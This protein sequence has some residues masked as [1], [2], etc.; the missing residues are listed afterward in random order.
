MLHRIDT[1][2]IGIHAIALTVVPRVDWTASLYV[3]LSPRGQ[4]N[5]RCSTLRFPLL[6]WLLAPAE[7][8]ALESYTYHGERCRR[9]SAN[10]RSYQEAIRLY[11]T[12]EAYKELP[13]TDDVLATLNYHTSVRVGPSLFSHSVVVVFCSTH[14]ELLACSRFIA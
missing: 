14:L 12:E 11:E 8:V 9:V 5:I 3:Q 1:P 10:L 2:S 13:Y 6:F 7:T 4:N